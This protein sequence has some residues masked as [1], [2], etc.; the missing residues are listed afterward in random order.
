[1]RNARIPIGIGQRDASLR[2][3]APFVSAFQARICLRTNL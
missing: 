2:G 3:Y 1:M